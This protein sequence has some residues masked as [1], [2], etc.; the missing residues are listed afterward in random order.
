MISK[1]KKLITGTISEIFTNIPETKQRIN[2]AKTAVIKYEIDNQ[3]CYS[4]NRINVSINSQVGDSIEIYYE[5]DN[6]TK[7]YKKI[8]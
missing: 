2:N 7:V 3:V 5:I 6:V 1:N 4:Q 8:L